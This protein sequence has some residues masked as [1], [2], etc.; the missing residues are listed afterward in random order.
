M[1]PA[2]LR[3][4]NFIH[5]GRSSRTSRRPGSS[6]TRGDYARRDGQGAR[7]DRVRR[8]ARGA[9]GGARA[10]QAVRHRRSRRSP[11]SSAPVR[12]KDY[13]IIGIKMNDGA[14]LRIHPTGKA[15]LK[16]S[17]AR[18]RGR[19]TRPRS[20]R[21]SPKSS[22]SSPRT[23]RSCTATRTTRRTAWAP[24]RRARRPTVG[25][26]TAMVS[27][28][29]S[30][31]ATK[32]AAHLLE[33]DEDDVEF[34]RPELLRQ[35]RARQGRDDPGRRLRRLHELPRGDGGRARGRLL[36]RP[37]EPDVPVRDV[38]GG[39]RGRPRDRRVEGH[40]DG[41]GRRLRRADQPDDRRGADPRR[42]HGGIRRSPRW[43]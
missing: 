5:E 41:R 12:T 13:D 18:R 10:G 17:A 3:K 22:G 20:R 34:T 19:G 9:G 43:S 2:E 8:P 40:A 6:T 38:R 39:G 30:E 21:S 15:I 24:M 28:R 11:R 36:L 32:I 14:E 4:K 25:A 26:A 23:S 33:V 27:R 42:A 29:I 1:D 35:G 37:A 16:I 31:K 7:D